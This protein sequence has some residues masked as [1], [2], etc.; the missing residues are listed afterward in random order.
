[1]KSPQGTNNNTD[2]AIFAAGI[3]AGA[4]RDCDFRKATFLMVVGLARQQSAR[5]RRP[6]E[7]GENF[8]FCMQ[9]GDKN[10]VDT[11]S[12]GT[13]FQRSNPQ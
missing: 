9:N 2:L 3:A 8:R 13:R 4:G 12:V 11:S 6:A 1:M 5:L 10:T 7:G